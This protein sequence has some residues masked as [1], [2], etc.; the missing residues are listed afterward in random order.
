MKLE[1]S[2]PNLTIEKRL[3]DEL[4]VPVYLGAWEASC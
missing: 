1:L 3:R 2:L 4:Q